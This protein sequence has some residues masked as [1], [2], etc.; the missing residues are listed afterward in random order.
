MKIVWQPRWFPLSMAQRAATLWRG[1]EAQHLLATMRLVDNL[2]EQQLLESLLETS[3]PNL[4]SAGRDKHYLLSAPF[5]Y[6]S[7]H[8]SRFRRQSAP[9]IWLGAEDLHTACSETAVWRW[10]FMM[11]SDGLK[12]QA[13]HVQMTFFQANVTG[14][15]IDLTT[16]PWSSAEELW[17]NRNYA[18]S[19]AMAE[20]GR[21][22]GLQWIR[23]RS[24]LGTKGMC[25]AVFTPQALSLRS[26][27]VQQTW[28]C[29]FTANHVFM[30]QGHNAA[31]QFDTQHWVR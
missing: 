24:T 11:D 13:L 25:A 6:S 10:R 17:T 7:S 4:P 27:F 21:Q 28:A 15:S 14:K 29:K 12:E 22:Q 31:Y 19:H 26:N 20:E 30:Q 23:Y 8:A 1:V 5:R 9:G 18:S 3:K 2:D 16:H